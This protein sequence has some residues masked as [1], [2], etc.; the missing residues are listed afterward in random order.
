L[1]NVP[2]GFALRFSEP[3]SPDEFLYLEI[4]GNTH[5]AAGT[6]RISLLGGARRYCQ[7]QYQNR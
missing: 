4:L 1:K 7:C 3:Q 5:S 6:C 2:D